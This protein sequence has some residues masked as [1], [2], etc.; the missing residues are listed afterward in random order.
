M[1][2]SLPAASAPGVALVTRAATERC[3]ALAWRLE[4]GGRAEVAADPTKEQ[5]LF[6]YA[7]SGDLQAGAE[8]V[9]AEA[10]HTVFVPRGV[11][12]AFTAGPQG[13]LVVSFGT[14]LAR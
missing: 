8:R 3:E 5:T 13:L 11:A 14:V 2:A 4:A 9:K 6:V 12:C 10:R 7:G 1:K